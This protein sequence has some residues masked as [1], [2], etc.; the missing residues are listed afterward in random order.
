M[1]RG[2]DIE[3]SETSTENVRGLRDDVFIFDDLKI[4]RFSRFL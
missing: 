4:L 3:N 2:L 1:L